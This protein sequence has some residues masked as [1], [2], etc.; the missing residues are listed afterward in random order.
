MVNGVIPTKTTVA[1][2]ST[3]I[4]ETSPKGQRT[5]HCIHW[6]RLV[7]QTRT[8]NSWFWVLHWKP[9]SERLLRCYQYWNIWHQTWTREKQNWLF[10]CEFEKLIHFFRRN[11]QFSLIFGI[12]NINSIETVSTLTKHRAIL[13]T[14]ESKI[15]IGE[16]T[17]VTTKSNLNVPLNFTE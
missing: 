6:C 7:D 15:R 4:I 14:C 13:A 2:M 11:D 5:I 12:F 9:N 10:P 3:H 8:S 17:G 1:K 16:P